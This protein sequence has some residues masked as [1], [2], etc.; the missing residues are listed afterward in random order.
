MKFS[1]NRDS[2][3]KVLKRIDS[4]CSKSGPFVI[5][6]SCMIEAK[7]NTITVTGMDVSVTIRVVEPASVIEEGVIVINS[8]RLL[9]AVN[10]LPSGADV[11]LSSEG[12]QLL[13]KC[14]N[15]RATTP[16]GDIAEFPS[17]PAFEISHTLAMSAAEFK[18]LIDETYF[19]ISNDDTR[20]DFT[21]AFMTI[22]KSGQIQ[23]VSTD[24]HRLSRAESTINITGDFPSAFET[25]IIIPR[26][27]LAEITKNLG[28][29]DI[30]LDL[31][32]S[33]L[34]VSADSIVFHINLIAG[35]FPDFSKVIPS[36]FE[37]H[38]IV[39]RETF[40]QLLRPAPTFTA[41]SGTV[42]LS[43]SHNKLGISTTDSKSGGMEDYIEAEYEGSGVEAGFNWRYIVEILNVIQSEK[44][45]IDITDTDS[46]ALIRDITTDK[47]DFVVMPM[48]I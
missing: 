44:V 30:Q 7:N 2:F 8:N 27:G 6:A 36:G 21:G 1:L 16:L 3:A 38:A 14:G 24:G 46:P 17:V 13:I 10:G 42:K 20:V 34:F 48:Q 47:M 29:G 25:G 33:K 4:V 9:N 23:L 37:H 40:L 43:L 39:G 31:Q 26:K 35:T 19:S 11:C 15:F 41:K 5:M 22:S 18:K 32:S 45:S 28:E 12:T